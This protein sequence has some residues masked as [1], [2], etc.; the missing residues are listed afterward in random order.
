MS[1]N[2]LLMVAE[3]A[4]VDAAR[5]AVVRLAAT[6]TSDETVLGRI[7]IVVQELAY[8]LVRHAG[9]GEL[10]HALNDGVLDIIALDKGP[11]MTDVR[12]CLSD[13]YSTAG[14]MG[15][16]LGAIQRQ[17][18]VFDIYSQPGQGTVVLSRF[19]LLPK[20]NEPFLVGAA[21]TPY[22]QEEVSGDSWAVKGNRF[23]ICD[24]LGHGPSAAVASE[25]A[26]EIFLAYADR[27]PL[28]ELMENL[29]QALM[30]TRGGA[31]SM[32]EVD[33]EHGQV[34]FCGIGNVAGRLLTNDSRSM[35]SNNGTLGYKIGRIQ[36]FTYPWTPGALLVLNS[37]GLTSKV[38]LKDYPGSLLRHPALIAGLLHRDFRR[39]NDDATVLVIKHA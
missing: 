12:R 36:T 20:R 26:R 19:H 31:L 16:G 1:A 13:D 2:P 9:H 5:R 17:S 8:N 15:A 21:G 10:L 18:D 39:H 22:P 30:S 27:F 35:V 32:A 25:K 37:D 23:M 6:V 28:D 38:G 14:T 4:H 34:S 11:G 3:S 24:G 7:A 29:H 33:P